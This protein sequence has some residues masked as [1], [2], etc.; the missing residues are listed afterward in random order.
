MKKTLL[1]VAITGLITGCS[2]ARETSTSNP[3]L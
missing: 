3:A 2:T 1:A